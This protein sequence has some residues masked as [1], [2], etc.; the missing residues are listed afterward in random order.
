MAGLTGR[1][2]TDLHSRA[3]CASGACPPAFARRLSRTHAPTR[4]HHA[5]TPLPLPLPHAYT[6]A[7]AHAHT[8]HAPACAACCPAR[9]AAARTLRG[10]TCLPAHTPPRTTFAAPL[11]PAH[12]RACCLHLPATAYHH[13]RVP[14]H[15]YMLY[16]PSARAPFHHTR[17]TLRTS[18]LPFT[19]CHPYYI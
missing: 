18:C 17:T 12:H 9:T 2:T 3:W 15:C 4:A 13:A 7:C 10:T 8:A 16:L 11:T 19:T 5:R 1:T 14:S 6:H